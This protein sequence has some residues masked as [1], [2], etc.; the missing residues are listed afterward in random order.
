MGDLGCQIDPQMKKSAFVV[1]LFGSV[2]AVSQAHAATQRECLQSI[3]TTKR[4]ERDNRNAN[5]V[6][7]REQTELARCEFLS[8][9][10][11]YFAQAEKTAG[12]CQ[13]YEPEL[14]AKLRSD[15]AAGIQILDSSRNTCNSKSKAD[16]SA[17][18]RCL[19]TQKATNSKNEIFQKAHTIYNI[20]KNKQTQCS[21]IKSSIEYFT[22]VEIMLKACEPIFGDGKPS[23]LPGARESIQNSKAAQSKFCK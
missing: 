15:A 7:K 5:A 20:N 4:F 23:K 22:S 12:L 21:F 3:E 10:K 13:A 19:D 8:K 14:A 6:Y 16:L 11:R 9:S 17:E 1:F 18:K 2:F